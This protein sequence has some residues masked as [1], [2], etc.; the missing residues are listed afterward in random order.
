MEYR[1][2][3]PFILL[4]ILPALLASA[5][6]FGLSTVVGLAA[7]EADAAA[8]ERQ[9][10][11]ANTILSK[12][13]SGIA[14][15]QESVTVW[16]DAVIKVAAGDQEWMENNVGKWMSTYF[17]HDAAHVLSPEDEPIHSFS[18]SS[19]D[20]QTA[21][22]EVR[23]VALPLAQKLRRRLLA[24][25]E[26]G[27]SGEVLSIGESDMAIVSGHLAIVSVKPIVSD[28]GNIEQQPGH[29]YL[30]VAIRYLD[31]NF[32]TRTAS[33]Y[34]FDDLQ[35]S[36]NKPRSIERS[37]A[38]VKN[39]K[40]DLS[41]YLSWR[42]FEPGAMASKEITPAILGAAA[43]V[44]AASSAM[45][46]AICIRTRRL[47]KSRAELEHLATHDTL[48]GLSNRTHFNHVLM[49]DQASAPQPKA[50]VLIDLDHFK[51]VN[52]TLGHPV[53]DKVLVAVAGRLRE[54]FPSSL[55]ARLGG[56]EFAVVVDD[57]GDEQ[58]A[59]LC[60]RIVEALRTP[61]Q[62]DGG[63][64]KIGASVGVA[65][66]RDRPGDT[67]NLIRQADVALY[68]AKGVGRNT[69]AIFGSHMEELVQDRRELER[70][71]ALAA[72]TGDGLEV[73]FQPLYSGGDG[74]LTGAEALLRWKHPARGPI[75]PDV[76][77]PIAEETGLIVEL[78][79]FALKE[80]CRAARRWPDLRVAVNASPVE[81]RSESYALHVVRMLDRFNIDPH[82]IEIE[83]TESAL[84]DSEGHCRSNIDAL[85]GAGVRFALDDFGTGFSSFGRLQDINV[86]RIKI[87]KS[88]IDN[89][90]HLHQSHAIV[91]A[92]IAL[93]RAQGMQTTA[94][95]VETEDQR[96]ALS[97]LGCDTLQGFLMSRPLPKLSFDSL[98]MKQGW[99][100][101]EHG[102]LEPLE[103]A[104]A[105]RSTPGESRKMLA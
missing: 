28:T 40:G 71:L 34:Q 8:A 16:D 21:F 84:I 47:A 33:D 70:D 46:A 69:Y 93:A 61:F 6:L 7:E 60:D 74:A 27:V 65:S 75:G 22:Q 89:I 29:E 79:Q 100:P 13:Q 99:E 9:R 51:K 66:E 101:E 50:V 94:E 3:Q 83:M 25:D 86:D 57:T 18:S 102:D 14:H 19:E 35:F 77:I 4:V 1:L 2:L 38:T 58:L 11:L 63:V 90:G 91:E 39:K 104:T 103:A 67:A 43:A 48:T 73:H 42:P 17:L 53:G 52:D 95:G 49:G 92:M 72:H 56:D 10:Q 5:I 15:D 97:R 81:L 105:T 31:G 44:F 37:V 54:I 45:G 76:F 55:T 85:R 62:I 24:G 87:D 82:R 78:G 88:F 20:P 30:H 26:T 59:F 12:M 32:L 64:V 96:V 80:A 36:L 23:R 98:L 68:H 41:G